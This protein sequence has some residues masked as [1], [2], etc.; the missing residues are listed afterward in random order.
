MILKRYFHY[1]RSLKESHLLSY[2]ILKNISLDTIGRRYLILLI[3]NDKS[4]LKMTQRKKLIRGM[5]NEMVNVSI[6]TAFWEFLKLSELSHSPHYCVGKAY[7]SIILNLFCFYLNKI[8]DL[9]GVFLGLY[10]CGSRIG[11]VYQFLPSHCMA[12]Y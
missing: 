11:L 2:L 9:S 10:H 7:G 6:T 3:Y 5:K 1:E 8:T 12:I 4:C